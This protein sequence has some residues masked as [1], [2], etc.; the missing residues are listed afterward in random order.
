MSDHRPASRAQQRKQHGFFL[1]HVFMQFEAKHLQC[2]G[3]APGRLRMS[4]MDGLDLARQS[5]QFQEL[6]TVRL[7]ISIL[8]MLD[9]RVGRLRCDAVS[10]RAKFVERRFERRNVHAAGAGRLAQQNVAVAAEVDFRRTEQCRRAGQTRRD[11][12]DLAVAEWFPCGFSVRFA[13]H[14]RCLPDDVQVMGMVM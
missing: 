2:I 3:E 14:V 1:A 4:R 13:G 5:N 8:D 11:F 6:T 7:V 12:S 9:E 10:R